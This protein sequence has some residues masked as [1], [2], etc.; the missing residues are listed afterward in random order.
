[1]QSCWSESPDDR[2]S[3]TQLREQLKRM[4]ERNTPYLDMSKLEDEA[5]TYYNDIPVFELTCSSSDTESVSATLKTN[6]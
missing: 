5:H 3:F 6:F 4:M 2:P 1:M